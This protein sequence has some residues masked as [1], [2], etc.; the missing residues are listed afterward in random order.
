MSI[1]DFVRLRGLV[2]DGGN[3]RKKLK[4]VDKNIRVPNFDLYVGQG[5][6]LLQDAEIN[7]V[8]GK[9]HAIIGRNAI[10]KTQLLNAIVSRQPPFSNIPSWYSIVHLEQNVIADDLSLIHI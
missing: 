8:Y 5:K 10:G 9:K 7:I 4:D 2:N 3:G 6:K 1:P